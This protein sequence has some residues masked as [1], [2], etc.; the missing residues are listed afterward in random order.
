M[1]NG[2]QEAAEV[3]IKKLHCRMSNGEQMIPQ[4]MLQDSVDELNAGANPL[5]VLL[6]LALELKNPAQQGGADEPA[7]APCFAF[8]MTTLTPS[9]NLA[10]SQGSAG[11]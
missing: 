2:E 1:P 8:M 7:T 11:L 9:R 4:E 5:D 6:A 3:L 10:L